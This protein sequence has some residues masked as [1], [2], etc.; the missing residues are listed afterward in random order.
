MFGSKF[1]QNRQGLL[2]AA[3]MAQ[4]LTIVERSLGVL[5]G[6]LVSL[7][8]VPHIVLQ[9]LF[10][11]ISSPLV[12]GGRNAFFLEEQPEMAITSATETASM[13]LRLTIWGQGGKMR[14][15]DA[16]LMRRGTTSPVSKWRLKSP[17]PFSNKELTLMLG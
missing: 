2:M 7:F 4:S 1:L 13:A 17:V 12:G 8:P 6:I 16:N 15:H 3:N 14:V 5:W 10:A 9:G 11:R